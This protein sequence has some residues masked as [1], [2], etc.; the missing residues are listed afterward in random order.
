MLVRHFKD[1]FIERPVLILIPQCVPTHVQWCQ[2]TLKVVLTS[3][4]SN[5]SCVLNVYAELNWSKTLCFFH[6]L[7]TLQSSK[8]SSSDF[9]S[10]IMLEWVTAVPRDINIRV[11]VLCSI[12]YN[13]C[14]YRNAINIYK[15]LVWTENST[16][17]T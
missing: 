3:Y 11:L 12:L 17:P 8:L 10:F 6:I 13:V 7:T 16:F 14:D 9:L 2:L 15:R 4:M 1:E 5:V